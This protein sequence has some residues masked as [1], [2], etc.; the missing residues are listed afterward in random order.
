[1]N[2]FAAPLYS[3]ILLLC[4]LASGG[5]EARTKVVVATDSWA[6]LMYLD[7]NNVPAGPMADFINR[8]NTV[9]DKFDF[10][11]VI[12][13]RLRV[14][15]VFANKQADVYPLR[16]VAWTKPELG[17]LPT[18]TVFI[19]NDIAPTSTASE[20]IYKHILITLKLVI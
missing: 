4:L 15:T 17:L 1:M 18:R 6:Q 8:M 16:T 5:V 20:P 9:Q 19:S 2:V 13:P 12:Y 10:E 7:K 11:L 3:L 14:D